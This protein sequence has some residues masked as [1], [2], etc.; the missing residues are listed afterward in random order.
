MMRRGFI[1]KKGKRRGR[2]SRRPSPGRGGY[3][4]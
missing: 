4:L 2:R 3:R 1:P